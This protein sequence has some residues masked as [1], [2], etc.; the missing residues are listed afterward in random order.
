MIRVLKLGCTAITVVLLVLFTACSDDGGDGITK[1]DTT[2]TGNEELVQAV[3]AATTLESDLQ[4]AAG[5]AVLTNGGAVAKPAA[6]GG[7]LFSAM[8]GIDTVFDFDTTDDNGDDMFP[9]TTGTVLVHGNGT[10]SGTAAG[11]TIEYE[12]TLTVLTDIVTTVPGEDASSMVA[13]LNTDSVTEFDLQLVWTYTSESDYSVNVSITETLT[14]ET[15]TVRDNTLE[16]STT[17]V[18]NGTLKSDLVVMASGGE[19]EPVFSLSADVSAKVTKDSETHTIGFTGEAT[20]TAAGDVDATYYVTLDGKTYGPFTEDEFAG[21]YGAAPSVPQV[22]VL[23][24]GYVPLSDDMMVYTAAA[25]QVLDVLLAIEG[26]ETFIPQTG[27]SKPALSRSIDKT[28]DLALQTT[29]ASGTVRLTASMETDAN[30][31]GG[32]VAADDLQALFL[33]DIVLTE[34]ESG[35]QVTLAQGGAA[36]GETASTF[37][38]QRTAISSNGSTKLTANDID[39]T[40]AEP[41]TQP[42]SSSLDLDLTIN[43]AYSDSDITDSTPGEYASKGTGVVTFSWTEGVMS[44]MVRADVSYDNTVDPPSA[45]IIIT[46]GAGRM[47]KSFGPYSMAEL[48]DEFGVTL[49][50]F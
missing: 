18:L 40:I 35:V 2:E 27:V 7:A 17:V 4:S 12:M 24:S 19:P 49:P 42:F 9:N 29:Y 16:T 46:V 5:Y 28:V 47:E 32:S 10:P 43:G 14:N 6:G 1:P 36:T 11:G 23:L 48:E 38:L 31:T 20:G 3:G 50:D 44:Y 25:V 30:L 22:A 37:T 8:G 26:G 41:D 15:I 13:I 39:M 34:P 21:E 45:Q 33:T